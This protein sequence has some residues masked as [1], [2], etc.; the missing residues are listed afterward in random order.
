MLG[1]SAKRVRQLIADGTL[2]L[3][4]GSNPQRIPADQVRARRTAQRTA[5]A[6]GPV[7]ARGMTPAEFEQ[8]LRS[9]LDQQRELISSER[10]ALEAAHRRAADLLQAELER[11]RAARLQAEARLRELTEAQAQADQVRHRWWKRA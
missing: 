7:R 11:E 6:S 4:P 9:L 2:T 8:V 10:A 1:R 3:V 5:P